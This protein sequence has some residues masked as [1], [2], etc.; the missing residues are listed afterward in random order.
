MNKSISNQRVLNVA[1]QTGSMGVYAIDK[2]YD[3]IENEKLNILVLKQKDKYDEIMKKCEKYAQKYALDISDINM[4]L[5][6]MSFASIK[7]KSALDNST[8]HLCEM[9]IQGTTMGITT[10]LKEMGENDCADE[11]IRQLAYD[12]QTAMEEFVD[13]LKTLLIN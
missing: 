1:Y 7:V 3:A 2:I 8:A 4:V 10:L 13:S 11:K 5:K 6:A 9:L 12:L